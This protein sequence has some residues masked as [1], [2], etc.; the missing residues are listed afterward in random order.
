MDLLR[1]FAFSCYTHD[2]ATARRRDEAWLAEARR[3]ASTRVVVVRA[4][5]QVMAVEEARLGHLNASLLP[6][7]SEL[8]FLGL[9]QEGRAVFVLDAGEKPGPDEIAPEATFVELRSLA[10]CLAEDE[11]GLA[12]QA[13]AMVG[14]HRRHRFCG[15]CGH[16]TLAEEAGHSRRC[17]NCGAHHFPRTDP[18][19]IMLV[20]SGDRVVIGRRRAGVNWTVL[21]GFVEPGETPEAAVAREVKEEVGLTVVS[22][23]YRGAQPWPF[24]LNLMLAFEAEAAYGEI[25]TDDELETARWFTRQELQ[26]G[27]A[28]GEIALPT[29]ISV[30]HHLIRSWLARPEEAGK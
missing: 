17:T 12:A 22:A 23:T 26:E 10:G 14:W 27:V 1:E 9:D 16:P 28:S 8:T 24:P 30:A 6:E 11:A 18:A 5:A 3:A 21:A 13:V 15:I 2:R 19:V 20:Y 25:R 7:D 29:P 4:A